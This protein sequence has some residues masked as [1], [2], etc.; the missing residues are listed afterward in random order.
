MDVPLREETPFLGI[1]LGAQMLAK[2]IGGRVAPH[3]QGR[4]E[5]GYYDI[6]PTDAGRAL[7]DWPRKVYQWHRA[8]F[9]TP[10]GTA[11]LATGHD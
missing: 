7:M 3:A 11:L 4:V 10:Q 8:G 6:K 9:H 2:S 1:C 5:I